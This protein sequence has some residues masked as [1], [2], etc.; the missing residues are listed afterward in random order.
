MILFFILTYRRRPRTDAFEA[1]NKESAHPLTR[2][3]ASAIA[4][5]QNKQLKNGGTETDCS[6]V[7]LIIYS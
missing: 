2:S 3:P 4:E 5:R 1:A 7:N 6:A